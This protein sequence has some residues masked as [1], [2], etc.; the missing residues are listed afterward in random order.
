MANGW[1][2]RMAGINYACGDKLGD[3]AVV[4]CRVTA[5]KQALTQLTW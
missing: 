2:S 3:L 4:T 5:E 1:V